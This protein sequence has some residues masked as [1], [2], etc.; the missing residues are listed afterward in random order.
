LRLG[1][2][3]IFWEDLYGLHCAKRNDGATA[4]I[5]ASRNGHLEVVQA[6]LTAKADVNAKQTDGETALSLAAKGGFA[7]IVQLLKASLTLPNL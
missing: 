7:E 1:E 4:L 3:V 2:G 6:L 5:Q